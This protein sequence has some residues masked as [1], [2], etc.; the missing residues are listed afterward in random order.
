MGAVLDGCGH[1]KSRWTTTVD[2]EPTY[3]RE[4][5]SI[6]GL[7]RV[8]MI[9]F[10]L[11]Y[12]GTDAALSS[13]INDGRAM[14]DLARTHCGITSIIEF[15]ERRCTPANLEYAFGQI[16][17]KMQNDDYLVF[18]FAGHG[19]ELTNGSVEQ[20][21]HLFGDDST[22]LA[23]SLYSQDGKPC[24]YS[25]GAFAELV[26]NSVNP[27]ARV[28]MM[29]DCSYASAMVD[30]SNSAWDELEAITLSGWDKEDEELEDS[31]CGG[32]FT[33]STL[34]AVQRLQKQGETHYSVGA[35]F[36]NMLK[37][38][39]RVHGTGRYFGLEHSLSASPSSMAW[40][41]LPTTRYKPRVKRHKS[42]GE[43]QKANTKM[44]AGNDMMAPW[45]GG[46]VKTQ[47]AP[48]PCNCADGDMLE[49]RDSALI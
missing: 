11:D 46:G 39:D 38:G 47:C 30:L 23:F 17:S 7:G 8:H 34:F 27:R 31:D 40:P 18:F 32:L 2:A 45:L 41:L 20:D 43:I 5:P 44:S 42:A 10:A 4:A 28:L 6:N 12:V 24:Q 37:E 26:S 14:A 15:Y 49:S 9:I 21:D 35:I 29:F 1:R 25:C 36:N 16:S 48:S 3:E 19:T 33:M 22:P 13:C